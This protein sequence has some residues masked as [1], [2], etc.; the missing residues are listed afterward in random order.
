MLLVQG[1]GRSTTQFVLI[2]MLHLGYSIVLF[3]MRLFA[4]GKASR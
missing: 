1:T 4:F 2:H 3:G